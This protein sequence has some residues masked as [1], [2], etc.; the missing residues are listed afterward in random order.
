MYETTHN[1]NLGIQFATTATACIN[2]I[3]PVNSEK[4]S[5]NNLAKH[6]VIRMNGNIERDICGFSTL[7]KENTSINKHVICQTWLKETNGLD[8]KKRQTIEKYSL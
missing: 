3:I 2:D 4:G 1:Y 7:L 8:S 6:T 5:L